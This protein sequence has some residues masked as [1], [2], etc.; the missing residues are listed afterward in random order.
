LRDFKTWKDLY[1][2]KVAQQQQLSNQ[3]RKQQKELKEN[4]AA[5][6]EQRQMFVVRRWG[7]GGDARVQTRTPP[8]VPCLGL[9]LPVD[10]TGPSPRTPWYHRDS[11][12]RG[13]TEYRSLLHFGVRHPR[14]MADT[15][16][17]GAPPQRHPPPRMGQCLAQE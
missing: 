16:P 4:S 8:C 7:G 11:P 14:P 9:P 5:S 15:R 6:M 1:T 3:L 10:G 17:T 2:N 12:R 13:A